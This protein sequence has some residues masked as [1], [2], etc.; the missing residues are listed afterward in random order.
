MY[1]KHNCT[2]D[3]LQYLLPFGLWESEEPLK[4]MLALYWGKKAIR[5]AKHVRSVWRESGGPWSILTLGPKAAQVFSVH[6]RPGLGCCF[7]LKGS[8]SG[9]REHPGLSFW[10]SARM[11]FMFE[12]SH[13]AHTLEQSKLPRWDFCERST[14][15]T[16]LSDYQEFN[17]MSFSILKGC[18][19]NIKAWLCV[20]PS[21]ILYEYFL[22]VC[23][24]MCL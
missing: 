8:P 9:S 5:V 20:C 13:G 1:R 11:S 19:F 15:D 14:I 4:E 18:I 21:L 10:P 22:Y 12:S 24:E 6:V 23:I 2:G 3:L 7:G 17:Y 16:I